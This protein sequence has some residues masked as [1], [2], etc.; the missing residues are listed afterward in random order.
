LGCRVSIDA[1]G[2][3]LWDGADNVEEEQSE[4]GEAR[5]GGVVN[6]RGMTAREAWEAAIGQLRMELPRAVCDTWVRDLELQRFDAPDT[7]VLG[8][9]N[10]Y[11]RDWLEQELSTAVRRVLSAIVGRPISVEFALVGA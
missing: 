9:A 8:V 2:D 3:D 7:L 4:D 11:G 1:D 10:A 5:P 6:E